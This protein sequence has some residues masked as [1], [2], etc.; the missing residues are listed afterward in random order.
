[1]SKTSSI[2]LLALAAST[3]AFA[4]G[5]KCNAGPQDQWQALTALEK[6]LTS[7]GWNIKKSKIDSGCYEVYGTDAKGQRVETYFHPK[8]LQEVKS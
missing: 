2:V 3:S 1:M 6:K 8:T 4:G 7:E 5:D